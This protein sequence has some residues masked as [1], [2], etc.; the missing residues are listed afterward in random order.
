MGY[1]RAIFLKQEI[2]ERAFSLTE[3]TITLNQ[4][5]YAAWHF[6]RKL[7]HELK[8]DLGAELHYLNMVGLIMEKNY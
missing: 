4:G 8:K 3:E 6:R 7:L 1:F 5:N 2:S